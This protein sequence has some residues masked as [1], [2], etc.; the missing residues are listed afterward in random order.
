[1]ILP[2]NVFSFSPR[3][4]AFCLS[5]IIN[6]LENSGSGYKFNFASFIMFVQIKIKE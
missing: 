3:N 6:V 5:F 1:M 2:K 4:A